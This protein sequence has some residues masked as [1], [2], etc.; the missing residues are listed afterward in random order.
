MRFRVRELDS[1]FIEASPEHRPVVV[2]TS[3]SERELPKPFLRR[4]VYYHMRIP[5]ENALERIVAAR[6]GRRFAEDHAG[7]VAH[8]ENLVRL[9]SKPKRKRHKT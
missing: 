8:V 7:L 3:N 6:L 2:I 5:E 9:R 4:C 1:D